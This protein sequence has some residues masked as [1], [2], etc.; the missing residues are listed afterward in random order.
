MNCP[1]ETPDGAE[2][3]MAYC[4]HKLDAVRLATLE[5][6]IRA[7]PACRQVAH[8]QTAV[9]EALNA[10]EP[11]P[12]SADFD[13]RLYSRLEREQSFW[14]RFSGRLRPIL[15]RP[16]LPVAAAAA[17]LIAAGVM[18]QRPAG[19]QPGMPASVQAEDQAE[20]ALTEM[21]MVRE[22]SAAVRSDPAGPRM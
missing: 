10:W 18:L 12:V 15:L 3:L 8:E 21:E 9:W 2:L 7:C 4:S 22:F 19:V 13:L 11:A 20:Q 17:I 1:I 14:E 16:G 5:R 6:H